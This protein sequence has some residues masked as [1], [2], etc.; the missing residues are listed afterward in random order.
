MPQRPKEHVLGDQA[1]NEVAAV[2]S[3]AGHAVER[4]ANDYGE[5]LLVQTS[6]AGRMDASRLWLQVKGTESLDRYR[7]KRGDSAFQWISTTPSGGRGAPTWLLS[8]SGTCRR[9]AAGTRAQTTSQ[10]R[11]RA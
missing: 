4:V 1:L 8:S 6:H 10:I 9:V 5:D 2:I 7:R 3:R 11:G